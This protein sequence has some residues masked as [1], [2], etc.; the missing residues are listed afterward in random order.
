MA[1]DFERLR[2]LNE[3]LAAEMAEAVDNG[4]VDPAPTDV[5]EVQ[6][7]AT[8]DLSDDEKLTALNK[9]VTQ[10][11]L[12]REI[13]YKI[14]KYCVEERPL[15]DIEERIATYPEFPRATMNQ[16][17]F[18][19]ML[20]NNHGLE[21]IERTEQ[22]E[23]VTPEMKEGKTEDEVDDLV[24]SFSYQ[25]TPVGVRLIESH[26][27]IQRLESLLDWEPRRKETYIQL[28][29]YID[30]EP[31]DYSQVES[32]L[33]GSPVLETVIDGRIETVQPSVFLDKLERAGVLVWNKNWQITEEGRKYLADTKG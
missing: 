11:P 5:S 33:K 29:E 4:M 8:E 9:C 13:Y 3:K 16:F 23:R 22:G 28:L 27:P 6:E 26:T 2:R 12:N 31:R 30:Q 15:G 24:F 10:H 21:L 25:T 7:E 1:E 20:T 19:K 32:L 14:L 18:V 17:Y